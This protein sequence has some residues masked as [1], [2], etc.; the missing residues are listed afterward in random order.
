MLNTRKCRVACISETKGNP[1][2]QVAFAGPA[3]VVYNPLPTFAAFESF[4]RPHQPPE[5]HRST[6]LT[7]TLSKRV[8]KEGSLSLPP[9]ADMINTL[10]LHWG[11]VF[12]PVKANTG[13]GT[14]RMLSKHHLTQPLHTV[15][16]VGWAADLYNSSQTHHVPRNPP[17]PSENQK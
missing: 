7:H 10:S 9:S 14:Q 6:P 15:L 4:A 16:E 17:L 8:T 2:Y 11:L 1:Y 5:P 12:F 3:C 13:R